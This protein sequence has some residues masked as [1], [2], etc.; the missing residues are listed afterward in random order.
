PDGGWVTLNTGGSPVTVYDGQTREPVLWLGRRGSGPG[1]FTGPSNFAAPATDG[2]AH[3]WDASRRVIL[4]QD[5]LGGSATDSS[6]PSLPP[7]GH[8]VSSL[9]RLSPASPERLVRIGGGVVYQRQ[10]GVA[11]RP[12][13]L[14]QMTLVF[15]GLDGS[16][17]VIYDGVSALEATD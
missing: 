8:F 6:P 1:D 4:G 10:T 5:L 13:D 3:V 14:R 17:S 11:A 9:R 12:G 16:T 2:V 15:V 7:G